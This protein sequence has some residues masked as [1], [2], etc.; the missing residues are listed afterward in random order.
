MAK[1]NCSF[2]FIVLTLSESEDQSLK[3]L[4]DCDS[5]EED[6]EDIARNTVTTSPTDDVLLLEDDVGSSSILFYNGY[7]CLPIYD[8]RKDGFSLCEIGNVRICGDVSTEKICLNIEA[9]DNPNDLIAN[10]VDQNGQLQPLA[11]IRYRLDRAEHHVEITKHGNSLKKGPSKRTKPS[12]IAMLK[13]GLQSDQ[14][15]KVLQEVEN[16][17]EE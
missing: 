5:S 17:R 9:L 8:N 4:N 2:D 14:P 1:K 7:K 3:E 6:E 11:F 16:R 13:K 12:A 15:I 10:D